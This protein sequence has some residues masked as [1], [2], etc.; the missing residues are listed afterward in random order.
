MRYCCAN[1]FTRGAIF[2]RLFLGEIGDHLHGGIGRRLL[3]TVLL[4]RSRAGFLFQEI[5]G[6]PFCLRRSS[7]RFTE[8]IEDKT[9]QVGLL[10]PGEEYFPIRKQV[11]RPGVLRGQERRH[12]GVLEA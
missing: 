9:E 10:V 8:L 5:Q 2:V 4:D 6:E 12:Q 3:R 1:R 11:D 7:D